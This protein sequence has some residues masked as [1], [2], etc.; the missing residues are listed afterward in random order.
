LFVCAQFDVKF[1]ASALLN[2]MKFSFYFLAV[3]LAIVAFFLNA[4]AYNSWIE[5]GS[6][7]AKSLEA[8]MK[9]HIQAAPD[10]ESNRVAHIGNVLCVAG[11]TTTFLGFCSLLMAASRRE[12][13]WYLALMGVF[14][15]DD[16]ILMFC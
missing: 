2:K 9:Q 7:R 8:A 15:L 16:V 11:L 6:H 13:G 14:L 1:D 3:F 4:F 12:K 10:T 5:A